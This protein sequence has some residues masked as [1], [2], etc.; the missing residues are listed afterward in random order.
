MAPGSLAL[1]RVLPGRSCVDGGRDG[2]RPRPRGDRRVVDSLAEARSW[3]P[4]RWRSR[5]CF[6][7]DLAWTGGEMADAPGRGGIDVLLIRSLRLAHGTR[8]AGARAGASRSILRGRGARWPTPPAE[9]GATGCWFGRR[10]A[11][12]APAALALAR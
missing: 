9:G 11:P 4:A 6:P 3:H 12:G 10:R 5:G 8:L 2:R 1:A 7:V